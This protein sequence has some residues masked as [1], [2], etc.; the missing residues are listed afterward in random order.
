M[1]NRKLLR[2]M[3][4]SMTNIEIK[5]ESLSDYEKWLENINFNKINEGLVI[6]NNYIKEKMEIA[7]N[8]IYEG[9]SSNPK[10]VI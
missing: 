6:E 1:N 2:E 7:M 8:I 5:D 10:K 3:F 4:Y 9:I